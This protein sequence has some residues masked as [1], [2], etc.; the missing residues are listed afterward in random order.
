MTNNI[1][2]VTAATGTVG[3]LL[4]P[5]LLEQKYKVR[6]LVRR[7]KEHMVYSS[8]LLLHSDLLKEAE[9]VNNIILASKE[10][11]I[12][13]VVYMSA[14]MIDRDE[15]F[16]SY[17][18]QNSV[19]RNKITSEENVKNSGFEYWTILRPCTFMDNF[20]SRVAM[21]QFPQVRKDHL[22]VTTLKPTTKLPLVDTLT[23]A[24]FCEAAFANPEIY[25]H[26]ILEL[27]TEASIME[28]IAARMTRVLGINIKSECVSQE[29]AIKKG[30]LPP[31][32]FAWEAF[33][34][35]QPPEK[36]THLQNYPVKLNTLDDYLERNKKSILLLLKPPQ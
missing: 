35:L 5:V 15:E 19:F 26:K 29:E 28:D 3:K 9:H 34:I 10:A 4:I 6:A 32:L 11:G 31:A 30:C 12:K 36:S 7:Q 21:V 25:K 20:F 17:N 2:L 23:I 8:I 22:L 14:Y 1:I 24:T 16:P 27:A 33:N 18:P 13:V